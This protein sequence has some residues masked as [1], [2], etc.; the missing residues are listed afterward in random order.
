M[1]QA[2]RKLSRLFAALALAGVAGHAL[3]A[4]TIR[5]ALAGPVT[6]AVAQ[7]GEMQFIGAQ[8]AIERINQAGQA[9][10][11]RMQAI[12]EEQAAGYRRALTACLEGRGYTVR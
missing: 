12:R 3:A 5:I 8:M 10:G 1:K 11:A 7:Y 9:Q 6:G 4:D 2:N